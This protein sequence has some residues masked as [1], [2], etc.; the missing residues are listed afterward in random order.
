MVGSPKLESSKDRK[1]LARDA[2]LGRLSFVSILAGTLVAFAS[3]AVLL[4]IVGG[5][6]STVG[7][8]TSN[9]TANDY[10]R[11][12]IGGAV[13]AGLVLFLSY[14]FGGY[15]AG[16]LA[17]RAGAVNGGLV[18]VLAI[19]IGALVA[20]LVGTQTDTEAVADNLRVIG[21]PTSG[22]DY[23]DI[24]TVAGI[25]ALVAMIAG[26]VL[27]GI[28]G[29]RWHGKLATRAFDP[30]IGPEPVARQERSETDRRREMET[31]AWGEPPTAES[32]EVTTTPRPGDPANGEP[33]RTPRRER[34]L[35]SG[36]RG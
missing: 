3:F 15:I 30:E 6:L 2:G 23:G 13:V 32:R 34:P 4:A 9:L 29:E 31:R 20:A 18:V 27:G 24:A 19:V 33:A 12:G 21:V 10:E 11:L 36:R 1:T 14:F 5:I 8:D 35:R 22:S 7:V 26:A 17:R 25:V 16:R 28:T